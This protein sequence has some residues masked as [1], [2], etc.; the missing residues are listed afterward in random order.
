MTRG[1]DDMDASD[2]VANGGALV[3]QVITR[4][5]GPLGCIGIHIPF[6]RMETQES[7]ASPLGTYETAMEIQARSAMSVT[8]IAPIL[9]VSRHA[10]TPGSLGSYAVVETV[11][12]YADIDTAWV[13][14]ASTDLNFNGGLNTAV[15]MP[16]PESVSRRR[17]VIADFVTVVPKAR[18]DGADRPLAVGRVV[19]ATGGVAMIGSTG[20]SLTNWATRT[21]GSVRMRENSVAGDQ[22]AAITNWGSAVSYGGVAGFAC[23]HNYPV[24]NVM[25][26]GDSLDDG[27]GGGIT[28][29]GAG[30]NLRA[31]EAINAEGHKT[32]LSGANL[33]W[34]GQTTTNILNNFK[35]AVGAGLVPDI[36]PFP[37]GS[38]NN[39][40]GVV[41]TAHID[42]FRAYLNQMLEVC[43]LNGIC[44]IIRPMYP[45][46]YA[47]KAYGTSDALLIAWNNE[48]EAMCE[49]SNIIYL[50]EDLEIVTGPVD[51]N[52]QRTLLNTTD[53]IHENDAG[54]ELLKVPHAAALKRALGVNL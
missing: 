51:G 16:A 45:S 11:A 37:N 6:G 46:N 49:A 38:P 7:V 39:I 32:W 23:V 12:A 1:V 28:Y 15:T 40:V 24:C 17:Y 18:T 27:G 21:A 25:W 26:F 35:D 54:I 13:G 36:A 9:S 47:V 53:G 4:V 29:L 5:A 3:S 52:G 19:F 48:T 14:N 2:I 31:I 8:R 33:A 42:A 30:V 50:K 41:T 44:P 20:V 22:S 34:S 43:S 10:S